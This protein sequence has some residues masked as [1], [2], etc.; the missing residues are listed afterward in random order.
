M[1]SKNL[2]NW[3]TRAV[4]NMVVSG[5]NYLF[6][7]AALHQLSRDLATPDFVP[8]AAQKVVFE[9]ALRLLDLELSL[10]AVEHPDFVANFNQLLNIHN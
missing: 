4:R 7:V 10:Q 2:E 6:T 8:T 1:R 5:S 9:Q 3:A